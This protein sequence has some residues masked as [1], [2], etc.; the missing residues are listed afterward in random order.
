MRNKDE[1]RIQLEKAFD[2]AVESGSFHWMNTIDAAEHV[3]VY[4]LGKYFR[5]AFIEQDVKR[6]FHVDL[7]CDVDYAKASEVVRDPDYAGLQAISL[8]ELSSY[9][10]IYHCNVGES[11]KCIRRNRKKNRS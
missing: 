10:N 4:G 11:D 8:D 3:C 2:Y 9:S 1:L 5:D 7:L 6:R